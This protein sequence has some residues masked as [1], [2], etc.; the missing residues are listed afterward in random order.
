MCAE[1]DTSFEAFLRDMGPCPPGQTIERIDHNGNYE[2][3][4]CRWATRT[5]QANNTRANHIITFRGET[6]SVAEWARIVGLPGDALKRRLLLGWS[7][8]RSLTLPLNDN[9]PLVEYRGERRSESE[10]A[11]LLG[12]KQQ[13]VNY[14]LRMGWSVERAL[15]TPTR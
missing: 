13:T 1:W 8:E 5:E 15:T 4:N 7:E 2:P 12:L 3:G 6:H 11:R 14:R 9:R 10:W